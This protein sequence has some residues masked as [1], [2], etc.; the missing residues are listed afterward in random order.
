MLKIVIFISLLVVIISG[1]S[2]YAAAENISNSSNSS[3]DAC[4]AINSAGEIGVVWVERVS[5]SRNLIYYSI[6]RNGKW[7]SPA[8]IPGQGTNNA[9]PCIS[10]GV[11][12]GFVAAWH[13]QTLNCIRFS[14]YT[15]SWSTPI[16]VSQNGGFQLSWPAITTTT[17]GRI[18]VGWMKGDPTFHEIFVNTYGNSWSGPVN[19]SHTRYSSKYPDLNFG[20]HGE[21]YVVWQDNLYNPAQN[22]DYQM[23]MITND[24]GHGNW[25]KSAYVNNINPWCFRPVVA[26]NSDNDILS[27]FYYFQGRSYWSSYRLNGSWLSPQVISD[28]GNHKD[29]D[30]Y[31]SDVCPFGHNSFIYIYRHCNYD[32]YYVVV[33]DGGIG[34]AVNLA[35]S[36]QCYHPSID[37]R[38]GVGAAASWTDFSKNGD[39]FVSIFNPNDSTPEPPEP[40]P[41]PTPL[42]PLGAEANYLNIP[43]TA[44]EMK[45]ELIVNR[46]LF[47][48]Q[49]FRQLIWA[50]NPN[51]DIWN[52]TLSKYRVYRKLKTTNSWE[53]LAEVGPSVLLHIDKN[54]VTE[55]NRFDYQVR[56]VDDLGNEFYAYNWIRWA[57]NPANTEQEIKIKSYNVYRKRSGQPASSFK[58]WQSVSAATNSLE[59]HS[60]EIRQQTQYDYAVTAVSDKGE[61]SDMAV[62]RKISSSALRNFRRDLL[63]EKQE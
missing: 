22:E 21:I 27:C 59:D 1:G 23:T 57:P 45:T 41:D 34:N 56:G 3:E 18:A 42:P 30:R 19:V 26:V 29:H 53:M 24:Q 9:Y 50:F 16:T 17:N 7:T 44:Q 43:L 51:W 63:G 31:I 6:R 39:V 11:S 40:T 5:D 54:G 38:S 36:H 48:V 15:G 2:I 28:V 47:T 49:Y 52:I 35:N 58:R 46:N 20:P 60:T 4:I 55:E 14:K 33:K 25:T 61:E 37:Y 13:D 32:I 10:R 8:S 62:A 12:S